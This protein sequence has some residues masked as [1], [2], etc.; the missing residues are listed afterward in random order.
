MNVHHLHLYKSIFHVRSIL[1][2]RYLVQTHNA[3]YLRHIYQKLSYVTC[4]YRYRYVKNATHTKRMKQCF[5]IGAGHT[6]I[7]EKI[8]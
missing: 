8:T 2:T 3:K 6:Y 1:D 4:K 7:T 5:N